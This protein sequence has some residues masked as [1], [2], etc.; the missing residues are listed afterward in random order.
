MSDDVEPL[1]F[2]QQ[3]V[4]VGRSADDAF[5]VGRRDRPGDHRAGV[6]AVDGRA[7]DADGVHELDGGIRE[8][9]HLRRFDAERVGEA[10]TG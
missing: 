5:R 4:A 6:K 10:E 1:L 3:H 7:I 8:V 2:G 9:G